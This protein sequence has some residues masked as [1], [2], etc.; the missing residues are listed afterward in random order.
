M[1]A[2]HHLTIDEGTGPGELTLRGDLDSH[3]TSLL[4]D[5]VRRWTPQTSIV[6]DMAEVEFIDSSGLRALITA[7]DERQ[8]EA[9]VAI[10]APS[11]AVTRLLEITALTDIFDLRPDGEHGLPS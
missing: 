2:Q 6:L 10:V 11:R 3:S 7:R 1:A 9:R 5:Q 8:G 4:M